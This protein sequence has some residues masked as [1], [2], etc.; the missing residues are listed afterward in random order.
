[1]DDLEVDGLAFVF[2]E[3]PG[4]SGDGGVVILLDDLDRVMVLRIA[5]DYGVR[6]ELA[7]DLGGGDFVVPLLEVEIDGG[8]GYGEIAVVDRERSAR[9]LVLL[10]ECGWNGDREENEGD[11]SCFQTTPPPCN[12]LD[13][14]GYRFVS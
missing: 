5:E 14:T 11:C 4:L 12:V 3:H 6:L 13:T 1:V 10:G 9:G 2:L 8:A 7:G